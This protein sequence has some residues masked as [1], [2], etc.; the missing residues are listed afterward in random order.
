[1]LVLAV[2]LNQVPPTVPSWY[3]VKV[4]GC[5]YGV[6]PSTNRQPWFKI[7]DLQNYWLQ[8]FY[9]LRIKPTNPRPTVSELSL[10]KS[11]SWKAQPLVISALKKV[12]KRLSYCSKKSGP[13]TPFSFPFTF[14]LL[15]T[16][17]S[18]SHYK[19]EWPANCWE[20]LQT[21]DLF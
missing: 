19:R 5:M 21:A 13:S 1:M 11:L 4:L 15:T 12:I 20:Q 16:L 14:I 17:C 10:R 8:W 18:K 3:L 6:A 9:L 7:K 2:D